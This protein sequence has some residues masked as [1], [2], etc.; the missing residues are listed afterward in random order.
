MQRHPAFA[1]APLL[2]IASLAPGLK[3]EERASPPSLRIKQAVYNGS[4]CPRGSSDLNYTAGRRG[5]TLAIEGFDVAYGS[6]VPLSRSRRNC[7]LTVE[8]DSASGWQ[9]A[10]RGV[11][12]WGGIDLDPGLVATVTVDASFAGDPR[13]GVFSQSFSGPI[14][15]SLFISHAPTTSQEV[16]SPCTLSRALTLNFAVRIAPR[17]RPAP[18]GSKGQVHIDRLGWLN[19]QSANLLLRPCQS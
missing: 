11:R 15:Q 5:L 14:D 8:L 18:A 6:G 1:A 3:A 7:S 10:S 12:A 9:Y 16:W 13:T 2:L 4:G 17:V 19:T